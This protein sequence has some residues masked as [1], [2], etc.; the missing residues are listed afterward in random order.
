MTKCMCLVALSFHR[1]QIKLKQEH[2]EKE[3][4]AKFNVINSAFYYIRLILCRLLPHFLSRSLTTCWKGSQ[5]T[6]LLNLLLYLPFAFNVDSG[7]RLLSSELMQVPDTPTNFH[8]SSTSRSTKLAKAL[9]IP[10]FP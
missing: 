6:L 1:L 8:R 10:P 4:N 5:I 2:R 9:E 7:K 3:T